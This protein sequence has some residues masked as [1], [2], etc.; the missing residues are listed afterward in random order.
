MELELDFKL[1]DIKL[2]IRVLIFFI[3]IINVV[4]VG[5]VVF[6]DSILDKNCSCL[7]C[8]RVIMSCNCAL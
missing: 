4:S 7:N 8:M 2:T 3:V 5:I 1:I 6:N